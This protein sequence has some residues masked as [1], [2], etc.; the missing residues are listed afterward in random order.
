M[1]KL[2]VLIVILFLAII[3]SIAFAQ[4]TYETTNLE[5][6]LKAEGIEYDLKNYKETNNQITI[7]LFRGNGCSYCKKF[8]T[9]LASITDE[10]GKYFKLQSYEVWYNKDNSKLLENVAEFLDEDAE[11]VPY[12]VIGNQVFPGYHEKYDEQIKKAILDLYNSEERYDVLEVMGIQK[13]D[14]KE[15]IIKDENN[16]EISKETE[17]FKDI[18]KQLSD[19]QNEITK[20]KKEKKDNISINILI[21]SSVITLIL[22]IIINTIITK[23]I[24]KKRTD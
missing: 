9:F 23:K 5:Q 22:S 18:E 24:V 12:I 11:G 1:K 19:T 2:K 15:E 17:T 4:E 13:N 6:T 3:P 10:Y 16:T 21:I 8:I 14:S 7:Y 20:L